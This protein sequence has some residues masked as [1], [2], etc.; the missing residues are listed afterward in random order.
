MPPRCGRAGVE[1][2]DTHR[3][4]EVGLDSEAFGQAVVF[5]CVSSL[6]SRA[7]TRGAFLKEWLPGLP[8]FDETVTAVGFVAHLFTSGLVGWHKLLQGRT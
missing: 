7:Q 5:P 1:R 8:Q 2:G 6:H 3:V 4:A